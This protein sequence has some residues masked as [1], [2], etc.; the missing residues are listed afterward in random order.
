MLHSSNFL[1]VRENFTFPDKVFRDLKIAMFPNTAEDS[2]DLS[3]HII[4][5]LAGTFAE[6]MYTSQDSAGEGVRAVQTRP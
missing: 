3:T 6:N 1:G 2:D 5:I 4:K